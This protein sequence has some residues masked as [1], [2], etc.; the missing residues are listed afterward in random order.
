VILIAYN[1]I[2]WYVWI[3]ALVFVAMWDVFMSFYLFHSERSTNC[4]SE[5]ILTSLTRS[6]SEWLNP[7]HPPKK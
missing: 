2:P 7:Q 4:K 3:G 1:S 6:L 5:D